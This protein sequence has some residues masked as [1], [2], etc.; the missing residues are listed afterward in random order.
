[1]Y[2]AK[3]RGKGHYAVHDGSTNAPSLELLN[4]EMDLRAAMPRSEFTLYYQPVVE[5]ERI[6]SSRWRP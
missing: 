4:L 2:Q 3:A 6:G 5:L 1:M